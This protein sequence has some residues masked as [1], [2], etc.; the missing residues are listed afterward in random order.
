MAMKP[1]KPLTPADVFPKITVKI[2]VPKM[3]GT[4]PHKKPR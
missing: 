2:P 1:R 4:N 3:K